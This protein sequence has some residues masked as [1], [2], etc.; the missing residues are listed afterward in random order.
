MT[1]SITYLLL[2]ELLKYHRWILYYIII[3]QKTREISSFKTSTHICFVFH[4]LF[5]ILYFCNI[6]FLCFRIEQIES[7]TNS[8]PTINKLVTSKSLVFRGSVLIA[9]NS[10]EKELMYGRRSRRFLISSRTSVRHLPVRFKFIEK[11][12][13]SVFK[14]ASKSKPTSYGCEKDGSLW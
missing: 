6:S 3:F 5:I 2:N 4:L 10:P 1:D 11:N 13:S 12:P 9:Y 7:N 14:V 8:V